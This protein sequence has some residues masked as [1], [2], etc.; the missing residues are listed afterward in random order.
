MQRSRWQHSDVVVVKNQAAALSAQ[1]VTWISLW[2][3]AHCLGAPVVLSTCNRHTQHTSSTT[4]ITVTHTHTRHRLLSLNGDASGCAGA[5]NKRWEEMRQQQQRAEC[6]S[7]GNKSN[8]NGNCKCVDR[9]VA[10]HTKGLLDTSTKTNTLQ[11]A[12]GNVNNY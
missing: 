9:C 5:I 6:G 8:H 4:Q 7:N 12:I 3:K 10:E 11:L 1:Q 2:P